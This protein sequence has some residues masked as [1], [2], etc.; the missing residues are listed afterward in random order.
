MREGEFVLE[1]G[2]LR[3]AVSCMINT[4]F[5]VSGDHDQFFSLVDELSSLAYGGYANARHILLWADTFQALAKKNYDMV[6]VNKKTA[7]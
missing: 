5:E 6:Q 4:K 2:D 7:E 1:W 3:P